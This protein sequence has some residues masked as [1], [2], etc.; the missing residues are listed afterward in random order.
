MRRWRLQTIR[1]VVVVVI[2]RKGIVIVLT[3]IP[4]IVVVRLKPFYGSW[5][6]FAFDL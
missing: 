3:A 2:K 4:I 1:H 6:P 5:K